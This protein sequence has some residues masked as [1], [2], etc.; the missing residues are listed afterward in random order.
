M[1]SNS[2]FWATLEE[3]LINVILPG[4][5]PAI[6]PKRCTSSEVL[7][8][9]VLRRRP[10]SPQSSNVLCSYKSTNDGRFSCQLVNIA[11]RQKHAKSHKKIPTLGLTLNSGVF[12]FSLV[13]IES[14]KITT[15]STQGTRGPTKSIGR[16]SFRPISK[17]SL[18]KL[19]TKPKFV[20]P[21]KESVPTTGDAMA[22]ISPQ[23]KI[24]MKPQ[25][26]LS[27]KDPIPT[28][29]DERVLVQGESKPAEK[30][31]SLRVKLLRHRTL[32]FGLKMPSHLCGTASG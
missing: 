13:I 1:A 2:F 21:N 4:A 3:A 29:D 7:G 17:A 10:A 25:V 31:R 32:P 26:I 12:A 8:W 5:A 6:P 11:P 24:D 28:I 18:S 30:E 9:R 15:I 27:N 19:V 23:S 14:V 16:T 22:L 20:M